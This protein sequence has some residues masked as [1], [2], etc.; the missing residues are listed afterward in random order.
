[1]RSVADVLRQ[2]QAQRLATLT[3][4]ERLQLAFE[5]GDADV[6]LLAAAKDISAGEAR[7]RLARSRQ[8]GRTPSRCAQT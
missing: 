3:P 2:E 5:L 7:R 8:A 1:M 4:A 6:A